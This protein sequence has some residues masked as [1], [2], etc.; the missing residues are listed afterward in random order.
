M[1]QSGIINLLKKYKK[2]FTIKEIAQKL[3]INTSNVCCNL[4]GLKKCFVG[5][6]IQRY[7]TIKVT[8]PTGQTNKYKVKTYCYKEKEE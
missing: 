5:E 7:R 4:K 2:S 3:K 1:S 8:T 6:L